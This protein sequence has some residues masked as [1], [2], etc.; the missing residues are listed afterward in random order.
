MTSLLIIAA[1]TALGIL[2]L[3]VVVFA[4]LVGIAGAAIVLLFITKMLA[5]HY[6]RSGGFRVGQ[7]DEELN[8]L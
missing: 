7:R 5:P 8:A 2:L 4:L 1:L 3:L 6:I